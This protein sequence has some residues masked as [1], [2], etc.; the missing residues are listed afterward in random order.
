MSS[1]ELEFDLDTNIISPIGVISMALIM[2]PKQGR[3]RVKNYL[4]TC[5]NNDCWDVDRY[6]S[7][8]LQFTDQETVLATWDKTLLQIEDCKN[9]NVQIVCYFDEHY[10]EMLKQI[11]DPP[12]LIFI[13][14]NINCLYNNDNIAIIGTRYPTDFGI[15]AAR[16]IGRISAEMDHVVVSGLARGCDTNGF[17][18]SIDRHGKCVAVLAHGLDMIY[19]KENTSL[20]LVNMLVSQGRISFEDIIEGKGSGVC[21][22]LTGPPGVGKTLTAEV[23]AEATERPL[24]SVQAAQLGV[25]ADTIEWYKHSTECYCCRISTNIRK[26][27][28][29]NIYDYKSS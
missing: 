22:L 25:S 21:V 1:Y 3:K 8:L 13:K 6:L 9:N 2:L 7:M 14:G 27:Y 28:I 17:V 4:E 12:L 24:L 5:P 20:N 10:P 11:N 29:Y 23:F 16:R 19:P 18:G 26:S 15:R